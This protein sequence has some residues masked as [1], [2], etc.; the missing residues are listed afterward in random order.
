ML[1]HIA[2]L[3]VMYAIDGS[4]V[5]GAMAVDAMTSPD[6]RGH[7]WFSRVVHF[8]MESTRDDFAISTAYQIRGAVSW[9][10]G[11]PLSIAGSAW[12]EH[13]RR[14]ERV[15]ASRPGGVTVRS[16]IARAIP[17]AHRLTM[18][19]RSRFAGMLRLGRAGTWTMLIRPKLITTADQRS[20]RPSIAES[21]RIGPRSHN[22]FDE[23]R[24]VHVL[25]CEDKVAARN[26]STS[27][28]KP[29]GQPEWRRDGASAN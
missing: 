3:P 29:S 22:R 13:S 10:P 14:P 7:G 26:C 6:A 21:L 28:V 24:L 4:L 18:N 16:P 2:L 23:P 15:R 27:S 11:R 25:A 20:D 8:A 19:Q 1:T 5:R 12:R 9:V 17:C